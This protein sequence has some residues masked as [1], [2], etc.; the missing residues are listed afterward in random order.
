MHSELNSVLRAH[1]PHRVRHRIRCIERMSTMSTSRVYAIFE[2]MDHIDRCGIPGDV[3]E[4]GVYMGGNIALFACDIWDRSLDKM[5]WAYDT[6]SGVP[7]DELDAIDTERNTDRPPGTHVS[8]RYM[9]DRWCSCD[10]DQV[11]T[12]VSVAVSEILDG[13]DAAVVTGSIRYVAGS[14]LDTIPESMPDAI[15][16]IRLD[17]DI[18]KPT[19]HVL[20]HVWPRLSVGGVMHIDDYQ[21]FNGVHQVVD[22]FFDGKMVYMQEIDYTA[23][24]IVRIA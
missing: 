8:Q 4:C 1:W 6:F 24:S 18:A 2:A 12:N 9:N 14:V 23:I 21:S 19:K 22:D 10:L 15:S 16:F 5:V 7:A 13:T 20:E 3:V 17:M 11:R